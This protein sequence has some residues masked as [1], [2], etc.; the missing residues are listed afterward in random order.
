M[1][2]KLGNPGCECCDESSSSSSSSSSSKNQGCDVG[3]VQVVITNVQWSS[4]AGF[5]ED[6]CDLIDYTAFEGTYVTPAGSG[7]YDFEVDL[8]VND[9][10]TLQG[11]LRVS[12]TCDSENPGDYLNVST[13]LEAGNDWDNVTNGQSIGAVEAGFITSYLDGDT[14]F[15]TTFCPDNSGTWNLTADFEV[16]GL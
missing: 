16:R 12:V 13:I 1:P 2:Y 3:G 7:T 11:R 9:G 8:P 4:L 10:S 14:N 5:D 6:F 15:V